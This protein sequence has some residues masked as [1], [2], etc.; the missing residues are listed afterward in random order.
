[1]TTKCCNCDKVRMR[2]TWFKRIALPNERFSYGYCP[3]CLAE[4]RRVIWRERHS[5][6]SQLRLIPKAV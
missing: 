1:M 5:E 2:N 6:R 3:D 4:A